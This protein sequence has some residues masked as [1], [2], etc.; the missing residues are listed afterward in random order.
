MQAFSGRDASQAFISYHRRNFPHNRAKS[1]LEGSDDT[2]NYTTEDHSDFLELCDRVNKVLPRLKSF[3]PW[4]YYVKALY[5]VCAFLGM[6]IYCHYNN[7]YSFPL[8]IV[9]GFHMALIGKSNV[10]L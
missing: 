9:M 6:E 5:I 3:A 1:A 10:L 2:V 8:S 4:H 7:A